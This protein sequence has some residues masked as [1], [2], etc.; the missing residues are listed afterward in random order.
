MQKLAFKMAVLSAV[1]TIYLAAAPTR[2]E[3]THLQPF[4]NLAQIP[5]GSDLSSIR[6]EGIKLV[7]VA[8]GRT[9]TTDERYCEEGYREP[10]GSM[11]C[12][13]VQDGP[14]VPAYRIT[15]SYSGPPLGSD[16]Y[17]NT[18]FTFN[19]IVRPEELNPTVRQAIAAHKMSRAAAAELFKVSTYRDYVPQVAIDEA[20]SV[21]CEGNYV[22]GL[23]THTDRN[24]EDKVTFKTVAAP[25]DYVTVRVDPAASMVNLSSASR[26]PSP[27]R[28]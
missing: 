7:K 23:W 27:S 12:P 19:V 3:T 6:F 21:L 9:S 5:V 15:Y 2:V 11:Y 4:T 20:N 26:G 28:P 13:S 8:T 16:E 22:D 18:D 1:G 14:L 24:C 25:S 17:G 10:G